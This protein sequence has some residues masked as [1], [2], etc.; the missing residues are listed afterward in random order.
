MQTTMF[1][2]HYLKGFSRQFI[3]EVVYQHTCTCLYSKFSKRIK[4]DPCLYTCIE[5]VGLCVVCLYCTPRAVNSGQLVKEAYHWHIFMKLYTTYGIY[6][7]Y[8]KF[9]SSI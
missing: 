6:V 9:I 3:F 8:G 5:C 1:Y 7:V 2:L 4:R